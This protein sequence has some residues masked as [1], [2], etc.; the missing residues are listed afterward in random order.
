MTGPHRPGSRPDDTPRPGAARRCDVRPGPVVC[1]TG[2]RVRGLLRDGAHVFHAIPY[3]APPVGAARFAAPGPAP[4][5]TASATPP[6]PA[7]PRRPRS[8]ADSAAWTSARSP[9]RHR[10]PAMA[11]SPSR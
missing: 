8:A 2:G 5:G 6:G 3:A 9:A 7:P 1:T 11:I 10:Y 4:S